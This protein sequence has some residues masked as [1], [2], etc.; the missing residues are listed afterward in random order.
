VGAN[1]LVVDDEP[2]IRELLEILLADDPRA[3][4]VTSTG[5]LDCVLPL[6]ADMT[7]DVVI[8]DVMF[9]H[10]TCAEILPELRTASPDSRIVV[11]TAS[12][13]TALSLGLLDLGANVILQK[14]SV[15]FDEVV[16]QALAPPAVDAA[17]DEQWTNDGN[18]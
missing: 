4:V 11:F 3:D 18:R 1:V 17:V 10:R 16:D 7:P 2:D 5:E 14:A 6:A 9:G 12:R 15:S 8:L 13:R